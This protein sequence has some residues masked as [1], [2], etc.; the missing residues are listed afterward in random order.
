MDPNEENEEAGT[1]WG[2]D[3]RVGDIPRDELD[4]EEEGDSEPLDGFLSW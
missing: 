2:D 3:E 4:L 1:I